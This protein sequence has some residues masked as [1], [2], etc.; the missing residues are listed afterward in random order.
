VEPKA[1]IHAE[2]GGKFSVVVR[3]STLH[4]NGTLHGIERTRKLGQHI[5]TGEVYHAPLMT[6]YKGSHLSSVRSESPD[7]RH[8]VLTHEAAVAYSIRTEN[9]SEFA[10]QSFFSHGLGPQF[11]AL[12]RTGIE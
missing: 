11:Q 2:F 10:L 8:L 4:S 12:K 1:K 3:Q 7:C 9:G 6:A 5:V